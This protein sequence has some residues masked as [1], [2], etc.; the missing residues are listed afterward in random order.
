VGNGFLIGVN[1]AVNE[2]YTKKIKWVCLHFL[3][4]FTVLSAVGIFI[5]T[6]WFY[7]G[8][9]HL[10]DL[11]G[12]ASI[13]VLIDLVLGPILGFWLLSPNKSKKENM[14]NLALIASLQ[15]ISLGYGVKQIDGQRLAYIIKWQTSYFAVSKNDARGEQALERFY[16]FAEPEVGSQKR[17]AYDN[18]ISQ[19][20]SPV[21]MKEFFVLS[22]FET[23][24]ETICGV[25]TKNGIVNVT[26][27]NNEL[28]FN[29]SLH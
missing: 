4:G 9:Y 5:Y 15:L 2:I 14:T 17:I 24:C 10:T 25:I 21:E 3:I 12:L 23:E 27:K 16:V 6:Q 29:K 8:R 13:V 28:I 18:F 22:D 1:C 7:A 11:F 26:Q 20:I 19:S